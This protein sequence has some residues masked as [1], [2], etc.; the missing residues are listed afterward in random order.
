[1][2][3][4]RVSVGQ[5]WE[6]NDWRGRGRTIRVDRIDAR[7]AYCTVLTNS[8][9]AEQAMADPV[10]AGY[11]PRDTR[12]RTTRILL[13]RFRPTSTGF[14][15]LSAR[16]DREP[17]PIPCDDGEQWKPLPRDERYLISS[18]GRVWSTVSG[19]LLA[20]SPDGSSTD[21]YPYPRVYIDS[22]SCS[23]AQ[24]VAETFIGPRPP[25]LE[26]CHNDGDSLNNHFE[27]LRYDT[28]QEN[29]RDI[30]R[31]GR[32]PSQVKTHCSKGHPLSGENVRL[33]VRSNGWRVR[34]CR[35]CERRRRGQATA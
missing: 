31:H 13:S 1:M 10:K 26:V 4:P 24:V 21:S 11:M 25:G 27:N 9:L 2:D 14:R 18:F 23:L 8:H 33:Y 35:S 6:D 19:R 12:G 34:I 15:F 29:I 16:A 22:K 5:V 28:H 30:V 17:P 20:V 3:T 7:Y 32:N